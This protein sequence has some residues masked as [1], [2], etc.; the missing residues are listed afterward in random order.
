[1]PALRAERLTPWRGEHVALARG[2][3]TEPIRTTIRNVRLL[4]IAKDAPR[5][6]A[7][8]AEGYHWPPGSSGK[9][10]AEPEAGLAR[11]IAEA[12]ETAYAVLARGF[13]A[14]GE[15]AHYATNPQGARYMTA[16]PQRR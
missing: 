16:L 15:N 1:V 11:L 12:L 9:Q 13:D 6:L 3:L 10:A 14:E 8:L 5:T 7:A 4:T 2:V